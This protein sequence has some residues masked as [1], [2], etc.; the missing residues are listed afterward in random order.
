MGRSWLGIL[1]KACLVINVIVLSIPVKQPVAMV[2]SQTVRSK[3][4]VLKG[5]FSH[6]PT[7]SKE[8]VSIRVSPDKKCLTVE[9]FTS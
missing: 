9:A 7:G 5:G 2:F 3:S 1:L 6:L 8:K 4:I